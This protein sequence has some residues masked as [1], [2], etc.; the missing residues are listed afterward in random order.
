MSASNDSEIP[1][2]LNS[3][4]IYAE[5]CNIQY[6][7]ETMKL[8]TEGITFKYDEPFQSW[9]ETIALEFTAD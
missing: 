7:D 9:G 8:Q 1:F 4:E 2:N 3:S 5:F 6:D